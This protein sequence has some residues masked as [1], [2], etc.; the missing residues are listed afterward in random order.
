[1]NP[2]AHTNQA[3]GRWL[4]CLALSL[5]LGACQSPQPPKTATPARIG[6][7]TVA[8]AAEFYDTVTGEEFVPRGHNFVKFTFSADPVNG[9]GIFDRVMAVGRYDE[10]EYRTD[11][12][13]MR[14]LGYNVVRVMLE[15]CGALDCI[16]PEDGTGRGLSGPYL[17]NV[18]ALLELAAEEDM[19]VW[20]TSNTLP[21][22]GYYSQ[23][24][25]SGATD[26][27]SEGQSHL[28]GES[29]MQAYREYY[30]DLFTGLIARDARLDRMFSFS[31]R[32]EH[33]YDL[34]EK[35]WTLSEGLVTPANGETYDLSD[36]AD[37][38]R[39]AEESLIHFVDE[40]VP[41]IKAL[42]PTALVSIGFFAPNEPVEWR[43]GDFKFVLTSRVL[44][45]SNA[46]FFD[47]HSGP[48]P[49]GF[50]VD[51]IQ[52]QYDAVG[53]QDKPLVVGELA[54]FKDPYP[55]IHL[56]AQDMVDWQTDT[57]LAGYDGWLTWHWEG[58]AFEGLWGSDGTVVGEALAPALHPDPCATVVVPNPNLAYGRP[59]T[60]SAELAGEPA[61]NAVDGTGMQWGSGADAPQH[62]EIDL[63]EGTLVGTVLLKVAQFPEGATVH[64]VYGGPTSPAGTLL[65]TFA[66][67][68]AEGDV[69]RVDFPI[70]VELRY[71]RVLTT[72]SP[73]WVAWQ[74]IEVYAPGA[75]P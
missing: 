55:S 46:D 20:L 47:L 21:D 19:Y 69:L 71:V 59:V 4:V 26:L 24:G 50:T 74:E 53:I 28:L 73:S 39:L 38:R 11:F 36:P 75:A 68:T 64:E 67:E 31:I 40:M 15:T 56:A 7:R 18:A 29:G 27:V 33:W 30:T 42:A 63:G 52:V 1:M 25:Y 72:S 65:H 2:V 54:G 17:D 44:R 51:E 41:V 57:C 23:L 60:A 61:A 62:I 12:E 70:P 10:A 16:Y 37:H 6:I 35:P 45:E 22:I 43:P 34:R 58:D 3:N 32:N 14:A 66:Q 8:G 9:P 48:N 5:V 13:A 49:F